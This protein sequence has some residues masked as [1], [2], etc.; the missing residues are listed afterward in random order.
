MKVT[1]TALLE[2]STKHHR[3]LAQALRRAG[4]R[5]SAARDAAALTKE[6]LVV[7]GPTLAQ[8]AKVA[9]AVRARLPQALVVAAQAKGFKASFADA[10][11]PLPLSPNDL[12]LRLSEWVQLF[13]H[14]QAP[15]ARPGDGI[16]DPLTGFYTFAHFKE[17]LFIEVKRA[18]RYGFP[19]ALALVAFDSLPIGDR[20]LLSKLMGGLALAIRRSLRDTDYPVQYEARRALLLMPHTDLAGALVVARRIC[21]RVSKASLAHEGEVLRPT[22]S[23][24]VAAATVGRESSFADLARNAQAS[25]EQAQGGGGNRVLFFDG[26]LPES[27]VAP[28]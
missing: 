14:K 21:E 16:L 24:G 26:T 17:V 1:R 28:S 9:K 27:R 7:L 13:A 20:V 18:R 12:K 3:P 19:L 2:P 11:V 22:I 23:V 6:Q 8:P 10:V 4:L 5:L 15:P 25:L